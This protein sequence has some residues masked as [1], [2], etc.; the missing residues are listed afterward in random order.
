LAFTRRL[1]GQVA[2][3]TGNPLNTLQVIVLALGAIDNTFN[4]P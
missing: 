3:E 1:A 2:S 4:N